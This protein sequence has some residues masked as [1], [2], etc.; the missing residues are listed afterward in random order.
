MRGVYQ[1]CIVNHS[2]CS[3]ASAHLGLRTWPAQEHL[4]DHGCEKSG[5]IVIDKY[6]QLALA[7]A[8]MSRDAEVAIW[9]ARVLDDSAC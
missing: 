7:S 4:G 3:G 2:S 6:I 1:G 9:G 5:M 8:M